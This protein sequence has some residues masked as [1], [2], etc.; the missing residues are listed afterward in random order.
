MGAD[1]Q[2]RQRNAS[3]CENT[4]QHDVSVRQH[5]QRIT[6]KVLTLLTRADAG[7]PSKSAGR[8]IPLTLLTLPTLPTARNSRRTKGD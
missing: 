3:T 5:G 2:Q 4:S 6:A 8:R 1:R 7:Q